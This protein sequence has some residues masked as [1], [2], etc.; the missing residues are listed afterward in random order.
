MKKLVVLMCL[1]LATVACTKKEKE[2]DVIRIGAAGPLTGDM[3]VFGQDQVN[4]MKLAI[5][6]WNAKGGVLGKK[7]V[8]VEGDDQRDPKQAVSAANKLVNE[9][10]AAV[11][12]H[13]NSNCSIPASAVYHKAGVPQISHGSTNPQLTEQGFASLF[14]I[15]GRD[16]QQGKVSAVYATDVLKAKKVAILHDKTTYGQGLADEFRKGLGDKAQVVAYDGI[17]VGEKDYSP[18]VTRIKAANPDLV[19]FG[20]IYVEGGL[21]IKQFKAVGGTAPFIGGDGIMSGELVKIGGPATE[22]TYATFGP[23][24]K[25]VPSAKGFNENYRNRFGEPGV[26]SVYAYDAT[27]IILQALQKVGAVDGKKL[28]DAIR[29]IDYNGALGHIQFDAKGDVKESPYVVWKVEEGKWQ[30]VK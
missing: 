21:L 6:E 27:N 9:G 25:E 19:F 5:D 17:G 1:C 2:A 30:Q 3:A 10:V 8:M 13:F 14:R 11:V 18:V 12:G 20:G 23:D 4:G 29:G 7:I 28:A 22:G 16:D 24:T 15:C 26:Y